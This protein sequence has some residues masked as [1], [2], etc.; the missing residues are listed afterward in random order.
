MLACVGARIFQI[1]YTKIRATETQRLT[2]FRL[3]SPSATWLQTWWPGSDAS[4][5]D[6]NNTRSNWSLGIWD[7]YIVGKSLQHLRDS[8]FLVLGR[9]EEG[10]PRVWKPFLEN[11]GARAA[12]ANPGYRRPSSV[13]YLRLSSTS[14]GC[15]RCEL[16]KGVKHF[17]YSQFYRIREA[18][19]CPMIFCM[20]RYPVGKSVPHDVWSFI[21]LLANNAMLMMRDNLPAAVLLHT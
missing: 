14:F 3:V 16:R 18:S 17:A 7:F 4:S 2:G 20:D 12:A 15:E 13:L 10:I 8:S 5:L 6:S 21:S 1:Q 11:D 19:L 9:A